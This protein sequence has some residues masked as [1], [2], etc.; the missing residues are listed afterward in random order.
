[1]TYILAAKNVVAR[2]LQAQEGGAIQTSPEK[3]ISMG[4][5]TGI[6]CSQ[7]SPTVRSVRA[8]AW[9]LVAMLFR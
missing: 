7:I 6:N 1:M 3:V 2:S 8:R 9:I 5:A 4:E